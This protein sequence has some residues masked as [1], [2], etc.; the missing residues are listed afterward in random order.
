MKDAA[1]HRLKF[2]ILPFP[3]RLFV[4]LCRAHMQ[5]VIHHTVCAQ[6]TGGSLPPHLLTLFIEKTYS[7]VF[8]SI[9]V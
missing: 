7:L 4:K 9:L 5:D 3:D 8:T 6:N 2:Y 1:T